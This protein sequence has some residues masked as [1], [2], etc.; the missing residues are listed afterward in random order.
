MIKNIL[1]DH[2]ILASVNERARLMVLAE[3]PPEELARLC[4]RCDPITQE[5]FRCDMSHVGFIRRRWDRAVK[6]Y[7]D[8][9]G[10]D[11]LESLRR[12]EADLRSPENAPVLYR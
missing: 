5:G 1:S 7:L 12:I 4:E 8:E 6:Q 9:T 11:V 2:E 10:L 3:I